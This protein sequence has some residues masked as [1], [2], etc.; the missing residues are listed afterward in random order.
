MVSQIKT[1]SQGTDPSGHRFGLSERTLSPDS[2]LAPTNDFVPFTK[3]DCE[4]SVAQRFETIVDRYPHQLAIK[5]KHQSVSYD[6]L[7]QS[8]NRLASA[9]L[10]KLGTAPKPVA[11]LIANPVAMITAMLATF[12]AGKYYVVLEP[13]YP[14]ERIAYLLEDSGA[15]IVVSDNQ[16]SLLGQQ[17]TGEKR[18]LLAVENLEAGLSDQ[19]PGLSIEP[20]AL[21]YIMY[22]SGSTGNPKGVVDIQRNTLHNVACYTNKIHIH[23]KDRLTLLHSF[24][25]RSSE[26]NL[27]GALLNGASLFPFNVKQHGI[28]PLANWLADEKITVYHSIASLFRELTQNLVGPQ[29]LFGHRVVTLSAATVT[30][31]DLDACKK[32]LSRD[33]AFLHFMGATETMTV[34]WRFIDKSL[35]IPGIVLPLGWAPEEKEVL[36]LDDAGNEVG[37]DEIGEI[38]VRSRYLSLGY[39]KN[40][41]LTKA[42]F[43]LDP[44]GKAQRTYLTGDLGRKSPEHGLFHLGRKD[45]QIKIRGHRVEPAEIEAALLSCSGVKESVVIGIK[46]SD[47]NTQLVAYFVPAKT[48]PVSTVTGLRDH[49]YQKIPDFMVPAH[50]IRLEALPLNSHGKLD[51]TALPSLDQS[52]PELGEAF[53]APRTPI[54]EKLAAMWADILKVET[55]GINDNFFEISGDSLLAAQAISR[56]RATF[57]VDLPFHALF[58]T[59]TIQQLAK[60]IETALEAHAAPIAPV[61]SPVARTSQKL[62]VPPQGKPTNS[63]DGNE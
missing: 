34:S 30:K 55:I 56:A 10:A 25:F 47:A 20:D 11:L 1:A 28:R 5:T 46:D 41:E 23:S 52:R 51:R 29:D 45:F 53:R 18:Q 21:S 38:A 3:D 4:Q 6:E 32:Y 16:N 15:S 57:Q 62:P 63:N 50:F 60:A 26:Y 31:I 39:W 33:C 58:E 9:I 44:M 8:A 7:N 12:K 43:L 27:Y 40:P 61:I 42:K 22:T 13:S 24:S 37:P 14:K 48:G 36:I 49:L 17:F 54:E 35:D 59:P 2:H 19:N